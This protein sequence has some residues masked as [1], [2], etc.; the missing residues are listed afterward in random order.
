M[1]LHIPGLIL[2]TFSYVFFRREC[3]IVCLCVFLFF[4]FFVCLCVFSF[5]SFYLYIRLFVCLFFVCLSVFSFV[6]FLYVYASFRLS[7]SCLS[8]RLFVCPFSWPSTILYLVLSSAVLWTVC[9]CFF[10]NS[11]MY[12][13]FLFNINHILS[14]LK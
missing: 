5:V 13:A 1:K 10:F 6:S 8:M 9:P 14:L 4:S 2:L 7:F 11:I 12:I 3:L